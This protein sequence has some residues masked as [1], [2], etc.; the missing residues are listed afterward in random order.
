[1]HHHWQTK[2]GSCVGSHGAGCPQLATRLVC[3][4]SIAKHPSLAPR[5]VFLLDNSITT[6]FSLRRTLPDDPS[7]SDA[8]ALHPD[9]PC[10]AVNASPL[11]HAT[12]APPVAHDE[13]AAR[14]GQSQLSH[15]EVRLAGTRARALTFFI[16]IFN[17]HLA[18]R[19]LALTL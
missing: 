16:F 7:L 10:G 18:C 15:L 1:M 17:L 13:G 14:L 5:S 4:L 6:T 19:L 2:S 9:P 11:L 8:A 12:A 3:G